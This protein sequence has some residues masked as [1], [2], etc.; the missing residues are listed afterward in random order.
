G[1]Q[2]SPAT[3]PVARY[4]GVHREL[5]AVCGGDGALTRCPCDGRGIVGHGCPNSTTPRGARL[6]A[7]G[8][9]SADALRLRAEEL[10]PSSMAL[11]FQGDAYSYLPVLSGDGVTCTS[12]T[13]LRIGT[14]QAQGGV[15]EFPGAGELAIGARVRALGDALPSG[16]VRYYQ[17]WY[18]D[19]DPGFCAQG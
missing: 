11:L 1:G 7:S 17:L 5:A 15:V 6:D 8:L 13:V 16:A 9:P 2:G 14:R 10:P 12:G 19:P 18:R 3:L 4:R